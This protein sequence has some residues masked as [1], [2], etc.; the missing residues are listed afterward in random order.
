MIGLFR[1]ARWAQGDSSMLK[2]II[3]EISNGFSYSREI[4]CNNEPPSSCNLITCDDYHTFTGELFGVI[5]RSNSRCLW[6]NGYCLNIGVATT[7]P[8]IVLSGETTQ[9]SYVDDFW[10][11]CMI[12]KCIDVFAN[13]RDVIVL[14]NGNVSVNSD[15]SSF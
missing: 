8:T 11:P 15:R 5:D 2:K 12:A 3:R 4:M 7:G 10:R 6:S 13:D 1:I 9:M 14:T